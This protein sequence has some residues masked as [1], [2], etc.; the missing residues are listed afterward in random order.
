VRDA[1]ASKPSTIRA[2]ADG[3]SFAVGREIIAASIPQPSEYLLEDLI[4]ARLEQVD[5]KLFVR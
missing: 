2:R 1:W 3:P 4:V 5:G